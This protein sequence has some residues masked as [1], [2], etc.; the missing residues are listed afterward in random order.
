MRKAKIDHYRLLALFTI[1]AGIAYFYVNLFFPHYLP[2]VVRIG[3]IRQPTTILVL[4]TDINFAAEGKQA[5]LNSDSRTDSILLV[6]L[7]PVSYRV[8]TL[9]IPRDSFVNIPGYGE[10]KV[11]A[12]NVYGGIELTKQTISELTG[13]HI[14]NYIE[15]NPYAVI[16]LI[17][18]IGGIELYVEK[19]MHY[20]DNAQKLN[21]NL[22]Q[23]WQKLSG[24]QAQDYIRFRHDSAGDFGRMERQQKLLRTL[25]VNLARPGNVL[26]APLAFE[27]VWQSIRTDLSFAKII[28]LANFA[29][30]LSPDEIQAYTPTAEV[31][32]SD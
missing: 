18:L 9:S 7:D 22:K 1:M 3:V 28:R 15:V 8:S 25:M 14:D 26:K 2:P 29:Q 6:R 30:M 16:R 20:V 11:N 23:G 21:I 13:L 27:I 24:K 12:A 32:T 10:N 17:D 31:G 5:L 4:G 19:D